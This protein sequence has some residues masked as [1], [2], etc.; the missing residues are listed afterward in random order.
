MAKW[1]LITE[2]KDSGYYIGWRRV[3]PMIHMPD[4]MEPMGKSSL[5]QIGGHDGLYEVRG[6]TYAHSV[7][8]ESEHGIGRSGLK[9]FDETRLC[10][11]LDEA[12]TKATG[13]KKRIARLFDGVTKSDCEG[14]L[15]LRPSLATS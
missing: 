15:V 8:R 1:E 3:H 2:V 10:G 6:L 13:L 4:P 9:I 7:F 14:R 5:V 11:T 12:R